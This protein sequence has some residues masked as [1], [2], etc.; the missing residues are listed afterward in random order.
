[1]ATDPIRFP[2][3]FH[4][5]PSRELVAIFAAF[6]S[7]GRADLIGRA[8]E[9]V[10]V[11]MGDDPARNAASDSIDDAQA[12]FAGFVYRVTRGVDLA[13]LWSGLGHLLCLDG[14]I[15][16][17]LSRADDG[18]SDLRGTISTFRRW[19]MESTSEYENRRG[20][21]HFFPEPARGSACKRINMLLRWMVRG[22]DGIDFGDWS[23][24][25]QTRLV[26]PLDTHVHRIGRY[27]GLVTRRQAD[28]RTAVEL[29]DALRE[30][31]PLDPIK[32]DF[33]MAHLGIS[34]D[35][36]TF[37]RMEICRGCSLNPICRLPAHSGG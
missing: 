19:V 2:H 35:C 37:R 15:G 34:G 31:D 29:T 30:L 10:L 9:E 32:Y 18:G 23:H 3:R 36:P 8:M 28:W 24:L 33:A 1:M 20:F 14:T 4:P 6:L 12:R 25:G 26:I 16:A 17:A 11:R 22:P 13:R 5:G 21:E 7:Y 27:L